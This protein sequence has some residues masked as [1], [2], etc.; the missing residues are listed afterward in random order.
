[1]DRARLRAVFGGG[2]TFSHGLDPKRSSD[3]HFHVAAFAND[4]RR[5]TALCHGAEGSGGR[6]PVS[7]SL[8]SHCFQASVS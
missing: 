2:K 7:V 5:R 4:V 3:S 1:M 8:L 6:L